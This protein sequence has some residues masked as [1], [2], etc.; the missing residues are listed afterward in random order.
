MPADHEKY[1]AFVE[2][3]TPLCPPPA[4]VRPVRWAVAEEALGTALPADYK[5]LVETYGGG[6]F[7]GTIWLLAPDCPDPMYDLVAQTAERDEILADLWEAGEKRPAEVEEGDVR[8]VP[9]GYVEGAGH[10]LYWL[11]RPG[12]EPEEWTTLLNEGRGP[13]WEA[14]PASCSEFLL[15]VVAGTTTSF[16]FDHTDDMVDPEDRYRFRPTSPS[17]A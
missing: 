1:D 14:H 3:L 15:G 6:V 9:W 10:F 17:P 11:V 16:Y 8:L 7:A 4:A 5:R 13:L 2:A 12:A